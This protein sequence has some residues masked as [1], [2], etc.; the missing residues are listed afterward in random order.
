[1]TK[2]SP[3]GNADLILASLKKDG[4]QTAQQL[5]EPLSLSSM[6]SRKHLL[7]LEAE[8]LVSS[9]SLSGK[10]GRPSQMWKLTEAGHSH[11]PQRHDQLIV[12]LIDS[13]REVFGD[14]GLDRLIS[15]REQA[16]QQQ[17]QQALSSLSGLPEKLSKLA[18]L[19]T[20]EGYMAT[21]AQDGKDWLLI[22][23]HCPICAAATSCQGFC[24]SELALF[25]QLFA[26]S[27]DVNREQWLMDGGQ[28][29]VYRLTRQ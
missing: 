4:P 11:F 10:Q 16:M 13:V 9:Y 1:M 6:G 24:R 27:A 2:L 28:R 21:T 29:C 14:D 3:K 20:N 7:S 5:A 25:Q 12:T 23:H 17:Y 15:N 8:G 22:E 26:G 18:E 19:R